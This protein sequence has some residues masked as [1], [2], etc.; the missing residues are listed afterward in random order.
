[1]DRGRYLGGFLHRPLFEVIADGRTLD[2]WVRGWRERV[3]Y[4]NWM[5]R[6]DYP[7]RVETQIAEPELAAIV[8][9]R[10]ARG[11]EP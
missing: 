6:P 11:E 7:V 8:R 3:D 5:V 10:I 4:A 2:V 1:V 9:A